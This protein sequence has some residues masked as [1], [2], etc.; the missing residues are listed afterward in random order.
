MTPSI[1]TKGAQ[2]HRQRRRGSLRK[3]MSLVSKTRHSV[4]ASPTFSRLSK[5]RVHGRPVSVAASADAC[6]QMP[7][8]APK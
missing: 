7:T 6:A 2:A 3:C 8:F 5:S 4:N 1:T